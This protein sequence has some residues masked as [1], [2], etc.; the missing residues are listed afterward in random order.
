[1]NLQCHG[2][3]LQRLKIGPQGLFTHDYI[4]SLNSNQCIE[5]NGIDMQNFI[6]SKVNKFDW[7]QE[8]K[9]FSLNS[10]KWRSFPFLIT[11]FGQIYLAVVPV[12]SAKALY[13]LSCGNTWWR[14]VPVQLILEQRVLFQTKLNNARHE[15]A[16]ERVTI[17]DVK[18]TELQ[19]L[20]SAIKLY[21]CTALAEQLIPSSRCHNHS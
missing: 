5:L 6:E 14:P 12:T 2:N 16:C 3:L 11:C 4:K 10:D 19:N 9:R 15:E 20:S 13:F 8:R 18:H 21:H 7:T 1:M 17:S